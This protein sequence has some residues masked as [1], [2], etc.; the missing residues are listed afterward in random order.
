MLNIQYIKGNKSVSSCFQV[1]EEDE[2]RAKLRKKVVKDV[3]SSGV[4]DCLGFIVQVLVLL[5]FLSF[6]YFVS[7]F[8]VC[9]Y[10]TVHAWAKDKK[11]GLS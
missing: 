3:L 8:V 1:L 2:N 6:C 5:L 11:S 4:Y 9:N 7:F 10:I